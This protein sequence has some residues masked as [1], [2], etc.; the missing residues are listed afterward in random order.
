MP[1]PSMK[2]CQFS[3]ESYSILCPQELLSVYHMTCN[4]SQVYSALLDYKLLSIGIISY[5]FYY[6]FNNEQ[7]LAFNRLM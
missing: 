6:F 4:V 5:L 7:S 3:G 1:G 2:P